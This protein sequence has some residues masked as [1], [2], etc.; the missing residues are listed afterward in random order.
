MISV[1]V[2]N[3]CS[4]VELDKTREQWRRCYSPISTRELRTWVQDWRGG[5]QTIPYLRL[6]KATDGGL[7]NM[8]DM[9]AVLNVEGLNLS[10]VRADVERVWS[11]EVASGL[12]AVHCFRESSSGLV[13]YF[14]ALTSTNNYV[15]GILYV[16]RKE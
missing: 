7:L 10:M 14:C 12:K 13:F 11:N 6:V 9:R 16:S 8:L 5:L 1:S 4:M 3:A 2:S 15:T